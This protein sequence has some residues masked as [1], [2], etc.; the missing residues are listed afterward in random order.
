MIK[1]QHSHA[2]RQLNRR[3][4]QTSQRLPKKQFGGL[5]GELDHITLSPHNGPRPDDN[6]IYIWLRVPGGPVAGRYECAFNT[7]SSSYGAECQFYEH[8]EQIEMGDFPSFGFW[9]AGVS[10]AGLG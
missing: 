2:K 6:H 3:P 7:E 9:Q 5:V 8:E 10:Y 1:K 4:L